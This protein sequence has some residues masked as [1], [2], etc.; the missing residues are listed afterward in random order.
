MGLS[1][2]FPKVYSTTLK[3]SSDAGKK[4]LVA[5]CKRAENSVG[6]VKFVVIMKKS[7]YRQ[8]HPLCYI[9]WIS[10][11]IDLTPVCAWVTGRRMCGIVLT[12]MVL[13]RGLAEQA[14][15]QR[16]K[17]SEVLGDPRYQEIRDGVSE[18]V[19]REAFFEWVEEN[20]FLWDRIE[21]EEVEQGFR[22]LQEA[23]TPTEVIDPK[24]IYVGVT[25]NGY[26]IAWGFA[27]FGS[28]TFVLCCNLGFIFLLNRRQCM[29]FWEPHCCCR[30]IFLCLDLY[31]KDGYNT[32][33][34]D[35]DDLY[36][37]QAEESYTGVTQR[38]NRDVEE[39][40][41]KYRYYHTPY[42]TLISFNEEV[43]TEMEDPYD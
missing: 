30:K 22:R 40:R 23:L 24:E 5:H 31:D 33:D 17:V 21:V 3:N 12:G 34:D 38:E 15:N 18:V 16:A 28:F 42:N 27:F 10:V 13:C 26:F 41:K 1:L 37:L 4:G 19:G 2:N 6:F 9:V 14:D 8:F 43:P 7:S 29:L 39:V 25:G 35:E 20:D 11:L 36:L 32:R